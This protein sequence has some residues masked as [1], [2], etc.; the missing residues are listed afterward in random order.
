MRLTKTRL[1]TSL[2]TMYVARPVALTQPPPPAEERAGPVFRSQYTFESFIVGES[3]RLARTV[4]EQIA[5]EPGKQYNPLFLYGGVGLGKT[6]L[7]HAIGHQLQWGH[8]HLRIVLTTGE[9]F[10]YDSVHAVR[11]GTIDDFR[12]RSREADVLLIDDV[13]FVSGKE[14]VQRELFHTIN[15]LHMNNSQIVVTSDRH[16]KDLTPLLDELSS[17]LHWGIIVDIHSPDRPTRAAILRAK[18][19]AAGITVSPSVVH[20]LSARLN[21]N[22]RGLEGAVIRIAA[23]SRLTR[24]PIS[25]NSVQEALSHEVEE[26]PFPLDSVIS[27]V[28]E[29]FALSTKELRDRRDQEASLARQIA[30]YLA[31]EETELTLNEIGFAL[32]RD[33]STVVHG[34]HRVASQLSIDTALAGQVRQI[35]EALRRL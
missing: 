34:H 13:H 17:R 19:A 7:L 25:V 5:R 8:K 2:E 30:M 32:G 28:S 18:A 31:R 14:G 4:S 12:A 1:E 3:N 16:P 11:R 33:H 20:Y 29:H 21:G 15:D 22:V 26:G 6:H 27:A 35:R 10:L 9:R 24:T 23:H